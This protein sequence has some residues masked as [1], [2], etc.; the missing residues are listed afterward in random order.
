MS[1]KPI[2]DGM[3]TLTPHIVCNG[4]ADAIAFYKKAFNAVENSRMPGP[5]GKIMHAQLTLGDSRL[6]LVDEF[7]DWGCFGANHYKGTPV[8][9]HLYVNDVDAAFAQA[10]DAGAT[11]KMPPADM[12]WG[13]RYCIVTDPFGHAWS[14][15][16][17]KRDMTPEQMLEEMKRSMP[18]CAPNEA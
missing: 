11:I 14:I 17:H 18:Q 16:T 15:A 8:T 12:F 6:M 4:A 13:D 3:H 5:D 9:L 1:V 10:V 7:A 2:P